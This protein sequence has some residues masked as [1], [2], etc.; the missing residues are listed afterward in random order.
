M[1]L[2]EKFPFPTT[3]EEC[4]KWRP[5]VEFRALHMNVIVVAKTRVEGH[6]AAYC[7]P[8]PGMNHRQEF[9][10]VLSNGDKLPEAVALALFPVFEGI[11]YAE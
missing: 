1:I 8:V 2:T 10:E 11:P 9:Q 7:G 4:R 6:W 3:P 5:Y